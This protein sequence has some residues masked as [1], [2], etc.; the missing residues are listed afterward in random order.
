MEDSLSDA[1]ALGIP[2]YKEVKRKITDSLH[3]GEWKPGEAI[4]SEKVLAERFGVSL[5]TVRKAVDELTAEN[6]LIRHQ[7][8]GTF[9]ASHDRSRQFFYFFHIVRQD[10]HK[11]YPKVELVEFGKGK[12]DSLVAGKLGIA[13]G[14]RVFRFLNKLSIGGQPAIVDEITVAEERFPGLTEKRLRERPN[15][16][17]H[18]Y[19]QAYGISVVRTEERLR[20]VKADERRARMLQLSVGDPLLLI[21]RVARSYRDQPVELRYSY[22]DTRW[23]EYFCEPSATT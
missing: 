16:L 10:G 4:P 20:A 13:P 21:I 17:Y 9:V 14:A 6:L 22:V 11:E 5:G 15:T 18:F 7:G 2:L 12:A 3:R 23:Y 8:R 1:I 19:Q